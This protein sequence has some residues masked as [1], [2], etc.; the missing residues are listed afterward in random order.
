MTSA[1]TYEDVLAARARLLGRVLLTPVLRVPALDAIAGAELHLKAECLQRVGAFKARGAMNAVLRLPEDVRARG[2]VTYSSGN[3]GQA[4]ALAA[5]EVGVRAHV[6]M[7]T[8]APSI[9]VDA[10]RALGAEVTFAGTT[11]ADRYE[12]ARRVSEESGATI[13]PPF[14]DAD[15]IAGQATATLELLE[16]APDLD[17]V[18]VPVGG[19]GL[20]AGACLA[21]AG[22]AAAGLGPAVKIVSVEPEA[23]DAFA[24]SLAAGR[25]ERV[26]PGKTIADGLRPV[27]VGQLNFEIARRHVA[28][29]LT[30][31]DAAIG[32][33][34][35]RLLFAGK[36]LVEPSGAAGLA[37]ALER[38]VPGAP[39]RLGVLLSGGNVE[40]SLLARL[41]AEHA[42]GG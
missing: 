39:R 35:T 13:V 17:A 36:V 18:L 16:A 21:A 6:V 33:A 24:R 22:R 8:D 10:V 19:G 32:R 3:H 31:D 38:K 12:A 28:H 27:E 2:V 11:S 29:A 14:D 15:V 41:I 42:V 30:V 1:P 7:P 20:L 23:A 5:R 25:R 9:K 26:V 40:P 34:A 4:V 37:A